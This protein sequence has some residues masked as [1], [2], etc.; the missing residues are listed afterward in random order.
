MIVMEAR[1][2]DPTHLELAHPIAM[3][4]GGTVTVS[5]VDV[6]PEDDERTAWA[7]LGTAGLAAAY[8]DSEPEYTA[9]LIVDLNSE[10]QT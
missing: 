9:D 8:G 7:A 6:G 3:P 4:E 2:V 10:P 5:V 1:V